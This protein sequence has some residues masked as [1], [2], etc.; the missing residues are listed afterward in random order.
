MFGILA[1]IKVIGS[2]AAGA[3]LM[4]VVAS[5]YDRLIDDPAIAAAARA[6][7]VAQAELDASQAQ[8]IEERRLRAF[9]DGKAS[10]LAEANKRF[11]QS[12]ILTEIENEGLADEVEKLRARPAPDRCDV[13]QPVFNGLRNK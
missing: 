5:A 12:R 10:A 4:Y 3:A 13:D 6:G 8:V 9:M 2:G 11:E 1:W 7:L